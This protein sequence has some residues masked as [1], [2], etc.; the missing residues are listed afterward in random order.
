MSYVV[1]SKSSRVSR[2]PR[3]TVAFGLAVYSVAALCYVVGRFLP[4]PAPIERPQAFATSATST[5]TDADPARLDAAST[6][7]Y[8]A[9]GTSKVTVIVEDLT[10]GRAR[11]TGSDAGAPGGRIDLEPEAVVRNA[12]EIP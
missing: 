10:E 8:S 1:R 3:A 6:V 9:D 11:P 2:F 12:A 4:A 7:L 5:F